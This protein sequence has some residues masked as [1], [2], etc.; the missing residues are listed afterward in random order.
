MLELVRVGDG[1]LAGSREGAGAAMGSGAEGTPAGDTE[2]LPGR[3]M[4]STF[5]TQRKPRYGSLVSTRM[6]ARYVVSWDGDAPRTVCRAG[7]EV[8]VGGPPGLR[9]VRPA[10]GL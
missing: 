10:R 1:V 6:P 4:P 7:V 9:M 2:V 8:E 5:S 3:G